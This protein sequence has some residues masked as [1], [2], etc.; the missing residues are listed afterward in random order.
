[1]ADGWQSRVRYSEAF[2]WAHH[3]SPIAAGWPLLRTAQR[4]SVPSVI[5]RQLSRRCRSSLR[6][7]MPRRVGS[8]AKRGSRRPALDC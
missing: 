5:P 8:S 4:P 2:W 1:M 3:E 6:D 7:S